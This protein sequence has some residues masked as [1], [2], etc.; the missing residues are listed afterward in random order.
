MEYITT[1]EAAARW[2]YAESTIREWCKKGLLSVVCKATKKSG[3]WQI[4]ANVECPKSI[5]R[6][7][8]E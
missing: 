8:V 4:P 5:K 1:K 3:R 2:G 7:E 6:N